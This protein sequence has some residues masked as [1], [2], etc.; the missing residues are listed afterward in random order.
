MVMIMLLE[1]K[2]SEVSKKNESGVQVKG[3]IPYQK[4]FNGIR[5]YALP[6]L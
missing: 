2:V 1:Y 4:F 6:F 3:K 5:K